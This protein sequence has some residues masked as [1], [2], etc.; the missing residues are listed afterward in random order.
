M[1][2]AQRIE[3]PAKL[4]ERLRPVQEQ[5]NRMQAEIQAALFGAQVALDV[6]DGW[7]WDG[8]GWVEPEAPVQAPEPPNGD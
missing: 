3:A 7:R 8:A 5:I 4:I 2:D 1:N 6:P